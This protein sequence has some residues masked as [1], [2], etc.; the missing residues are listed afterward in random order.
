MVL[1]LGAVFD[2][3]VQFK[4]CRPICAK[5]G[6]FVLGSLAAE[7]LAVG[8]SWKLAFFKDTDGILCVALKKVSAHVVPA[9]DA[10]LGAVGYWACDT[11]Q[12]TFV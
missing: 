6:V 2:L 11:C 9:A 1:S 10:H 7:E 8:A 4:S 5:F 3:L 12:M